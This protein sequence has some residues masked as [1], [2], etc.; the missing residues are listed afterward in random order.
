MD[1]SLVFVS[2]LVPGPAPGSAPDFTFFL[3]GPKGVERCAGSLGKLRR[4]AFMWCLLVPRF[5]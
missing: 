1:G 3:L 4:A 5:R 2:S